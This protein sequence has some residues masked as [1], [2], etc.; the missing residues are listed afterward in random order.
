VL[1]PA[2]PPAPPPP[3]ALPAPTALPPPP[4]PPAIAAAPAAPPEAA[5]PSLPQGLINRVAWSYSKDLAKC[6]GKEALKGEVVVKFLVAPDGRVTTPQ[7]TTKM[8]K[9]KLAACILRSLMRWKFPP[10]PPTGAQGT[11]S[12]VFQ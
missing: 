2:L 8:G 4:A 9:P 10:Q 12:L 6:E 7:I 1:G 3:A 11:Y 5:L